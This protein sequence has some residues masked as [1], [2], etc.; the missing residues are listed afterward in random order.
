[1]WSDTTETTTYFAAFGIDRGS[2][3][4]ACFAHNHP[5]DNREDIYMRLQQNAKV[6]DQW[7]I[8]PRSS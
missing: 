2:E 7:P 5:D 8:R 6:V 4:T 3:T 1:M